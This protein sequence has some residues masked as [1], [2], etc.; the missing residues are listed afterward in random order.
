M[1]KLWNRRFVLICLINL[2]LF[3]GFHMLVATFPFFVQT[4]GGDEATAGLAAWLFCLSAVFLRPLIGWLLDHFGRRSMIFIGLL[5][6][7]LFPLSYTLTAGLILALLLRTVQGVFW[8][9]SS[10]SVSTSAAD[11]I[12]GP[13]ISEGMGFFGLAA[14]LSTAIGPAIGIMLMNRCG[15][16][17]LFVCAGAFAMIAFVLLLFLQLPAWIRPQQTAWRG[18][19]DL[20]ERDAL[21][22]SAIMFCFLLCYGGVSNFVALYALHVAGMENGGVYFTCMAL[23]TALMRV[24]TGRLAD[25][26]GEGPIVY[27]SNGC[28][29]VSLLL[30]A[31]TSQ[32]PAFILS[33]LL[34]GCGFGMLSPVM[35]AMAIRIAPPHRRGAANSTFLCAYDIGVGFGG[36]LAGLL[37]KFFGYRLMY[38]LLPVFALVSVFL[39]IVWGRKSKSAFRNSRGA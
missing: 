22:A 35:Q 8:A 20:W 21:P 33:A 23:T 39:Y 37:V 6:M 15:Y 7:I 29:V 9:C 28:A 11:I 12:P 16:R 2:F 36:A 19:S 18:L 5:G 17:M 1:E 32:L 24:V 4:L 3:L 14:A 34:F 27:L 26:R 31:L 13:R 25:V 30:L 38:L 10:T